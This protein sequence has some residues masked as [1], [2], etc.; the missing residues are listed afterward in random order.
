[1]TKKRGD[2]PEVVV[3]GL[4]KVVDHLPQS[5]QPSTGIGNAAEIQGPSISTCRT[6]LDFRSVLGNP[7]YGF[8]A[9]EFVGITQVRCAQWP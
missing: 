8:Y 1:M 3:V 7:Y 2:T 6:F 5:L 4:G 9:R